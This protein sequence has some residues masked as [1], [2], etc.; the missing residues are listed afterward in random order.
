MS[1]SKVCLE[2]GDIDMLEAQATCLRDQVLISLLYDTAARISE[3]LAIAVPDIDFGRST[4][5]IEHLKLRIK[6]SCPGCGTRLSK[7]ARFCPGCGNKIDQAKVEEKENHRFRTLPL[8]PAT[9]KLIREYIDR[10]GPVLKD[11][12]QMLFGITRNRAWEII[13][14]CADRAGLPK[15]INS[16]TRKLHG[17]SP[18]RIRDAFATHALE[19]DD[20]GLGQRLLQ[21]QLGHVSFSTTARYKKVSGKELK[22]WHKKLREGR[23]DGGTSGSTNQG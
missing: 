13:R 20:S 1:E 17:V 14:G 21:E 2:P 23:K 15:L 18:H 16:E 4:V 7:T 9:L 11:G 5:T 10:G 22:Q 19:V 6:R 12:K 3:A 8:D